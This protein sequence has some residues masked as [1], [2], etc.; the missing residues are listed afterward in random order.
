[1]SVGHRVGGGGGG[2]GLGEAMNVVF[3]IKTILFRS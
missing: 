2:G 3:T 1:M